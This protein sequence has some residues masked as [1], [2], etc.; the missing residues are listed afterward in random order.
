MELEQLEELKAIISKEIELRMEI[1][2]RDLVPRPSSN[3]DD[4]GFLSHW[5]E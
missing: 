4:G 1:I 2:K 5:L 3:W